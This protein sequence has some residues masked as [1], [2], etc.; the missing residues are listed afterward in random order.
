MVGTVA[1][2][3]KLLRAPSLC[4]KHEETPRDDGATPWGRIA[5]A[6]PHP[7]EITV[8]TRP[9]FTAC[10]YSLECPPQ[11]PTIPAGLHS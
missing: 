10:V 7:V 8:P 4:A 6:L 5:G 9:A 1:R 2:S 3:V 11:T